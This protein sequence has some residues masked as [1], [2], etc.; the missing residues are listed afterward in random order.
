MSHQPKRSRFED[1]SPGSH[2]RSRSSRSRSAH[3]DRDYGKDRSNYQHSPPRKYADVSPRRTSDDRYS[4]PRRES[5]FS[6]ADNISSPR[7][8]ASTE[9]LSPP[10][11][12][13]FSPSPPRRQSERGPTRDGERDLSPPRRDRDLSPPRRDRDLSPPRRPAARDDLSP[14]RRHSTAAAADL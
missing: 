4:P 13:T 9:D 7:R 1:D 3:R 12:R 6:R 2:R 10:R 11:R 8:R 14:V 5:R